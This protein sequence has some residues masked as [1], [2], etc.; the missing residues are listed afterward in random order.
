MTYIT[1]NKL[2]SLTRYDVKTLYLFKRYLTK[3]NLY[4]L[5]REYFF[6]ANY[7]RF[8]KKA[9]KDTNILVIGEYIK[10]KN[11][12]DTPMKRLLSYD[13]VFSWSMTKNGWDFWH[14]VYEGFY[15]FYNREIKNIT[16]EQ[17]EILYEL[18]KRTKL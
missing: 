3:R 17:S 1:R 15:E 10:R 2:G 11:S 18:Y 16:L 9:N 4:R 7:F 13:Y 14:N 8:S 5:W 6:N 12:D